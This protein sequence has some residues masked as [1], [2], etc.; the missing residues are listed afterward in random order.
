MIKM[1]YM[2]GGSKVE[3]NFDTV[4]ELERFNERRMEKLE[5]Q[6]MKD[7][8][9]LEAERAEAYSFFAKGFLKAKSAGLS[10][11]ETV[12]LISCVLK[13]LLDGKV[14]FGDD[15]GDEGRGGVG[16][17][18]CDAGDACEDDGGEGGVGG[19]ACVGR[20]DDEEKEEGCA[21]DGDVTKL[22]SFPSGTKCSG[23]GKRCLG[24]KSG[25]K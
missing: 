25:G 22:V 10:S 13:D 8:E 2:S 7:E 17:V 14:D 9:R 1:T 21:G 4:E 6:R 12:D 24:R 19:S 18:G 23:C 11:D 20:P 16:G 5:A 15:D 3:L